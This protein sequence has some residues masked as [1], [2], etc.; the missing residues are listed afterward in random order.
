MYLY[1]VLFTIHLKYKWLCNWNW[2]TSLFEILC[3]VRSAFFLGFEGFNGVYSIWNLIESAYL[4]FFLTGI[5]TLVHSLQCLVF[6]QWKSIIPFHFLPPLKSHV[7]HLA[8]SN[9]TPL[10]VRAGVLFLS[11]YSL[12]TM[13]LTSELTTDEQC[14]PPLS[15]IWPGRSC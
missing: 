9:Y 13:D 4:S 7:V 5:R 6:F 14:M 11:T 15:L 10:F 1:S 12:Q 3:C 2:D 8:W